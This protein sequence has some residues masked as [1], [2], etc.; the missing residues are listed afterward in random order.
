MRNTLVYSQYKFE[1]DITVTNGTYK[2]G[3]GLLV[4]GNLLFGQRVGL[5][6]KSSAHLRRTPVDLPRTAGDAFER[7]NND[8]DRVRRTMVIL[9]SEDIAELE[10]GWEMKREWGEITRAREASV[11]M[12]DGGGERVK[13]TTNK[14]TATKLD[15]WQG[16]RLVQNVTRFQPFSY[17]AKG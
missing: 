3:E 7:S 9:V 17:P 15:A 4:L 13:G 16:G 14:P 2:Q 5:E 8:D 11:E 6:V 10:N 1:F 12:G